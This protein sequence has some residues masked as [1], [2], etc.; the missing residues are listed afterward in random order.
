MK[1]KHICFAVAAVMTVSLFGMDTHKNIS[2]KAD[3]EP[4]KIMALGD[5]ITDGYFGAD[6]YRKYLYHELETM[7]YSIDM[8]GA[9]SGG[10]TY[11]GLNGE[12][13]SYDGDHSGYSG[14]T[15]EDISGTETRSGI[16]QVIQSTDM[17]KSCDPD[18][19][20]LQIGTNDILSAYNDG[21]IDR[22]ENLIDVILEDM[23]EQSILYV[24]TIPYFDAVTINDWL[25]AYGDLKW[26]NTEEDFA[27]IVEG[28]I[29]SYNNDIE[30]L[31]FNLQTENKPVKLADINSVINI[32]T[33]LQDG[34]HPNENGYE[35]MGKY[36]ANL[37]SDELSGNSSQP[38]ETTTKNT[39]N[40]GDVNNDGIIDVSDVVFLQ[41]YLIKSYDEIKIDSEN[42]D[43]NFDGKVNV[44]DAI[45]LKRMVFSYST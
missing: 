8:V 1:I 41:K 20:L 44:F 5:S 40:Q 27:E 18:I 32:S 34:I 26:S 30:N 12:S 3:N 2:V 29:D 15:I 25:W 33:D 35:K 4:I 42:S 14:Y 21:I 9:K 37:L 22:L 43:L 36:W 11:T 23:T 38:T 10:S 6:G 24:A 19:V 45:I 31:V 17:V 16:L 7:G 39:A 13:F 28:Y